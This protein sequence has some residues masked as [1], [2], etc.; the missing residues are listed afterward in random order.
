MRES[1]IR[2]PGWLA[3]YIRVLRMARKPTKEEFKMV[4]K[5]SIAG[6]AIIGTIGFLIYLLMVELPRALF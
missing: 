5:V 1:S 6:I 4:A 2:L 3:E